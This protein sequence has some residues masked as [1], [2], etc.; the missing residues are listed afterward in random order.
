MAV[1]EEYEQAYKSALEMIKNRT[2]KLEILAFLTRSAEKAAGSGTVSSILL[3]DKD[4]LLR[5]GSSPL[6]PADYL[7]AIDGLK[8]HPG[9]GTCAAAAATASVV[10][11]EDFH[12]DDK[13]SELRHLPLSLGYKG[14]WSTP[15]ITETGK[16]LGTFGTYFREK[17]I[18]TEAE[19]K[20]VKLLAS[21]ASLALSDGSND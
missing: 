20:G 8:P 7:K 3:L 4:G 17:R 19:I 6:L 16:V 18:P 15:I 12:A 11:T 5:N 2:P 1:H 13:W 14:A 10:I 21:V 9:V